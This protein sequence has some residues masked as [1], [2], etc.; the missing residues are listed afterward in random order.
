MQIDR[1]T[2]FILTVI[3]AALVMIAL[4]PFITP[5]VK[6]TP[7]YAQFEPIATQSPA[8]IDGWPTDQN[9]NPMGSYVYP[10]HMY[11][12]NPKNR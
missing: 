5:I 12:I 7:V 3:A 8:K 6:P 2:K 4:Q 9:G 11:M 10:M 1:Y